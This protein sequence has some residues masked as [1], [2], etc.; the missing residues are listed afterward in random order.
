MQAILVVVVSA[1]LSLILP[2]LSYLSGAAVALVTLRVGKQ[3]GLLLVLWA[4]LVVAVAGLLLFNNPM[5]ALAFAFALW[6]P[7][8][9]MAASLRRTARPARSIVL[10]AV[11]GLM[12]VVAFH[13]S[14]VDTTQWWF[15]LLRDAL[16]AT[17]DQL[18]EAERAQMLLNLEGIA[19]LMTGVSGAALSA[20]LI[21]SLV[22]GRWWQA[23]LYNPGGF[24]DE[25]RRISLGRG[26]A[27]AALL[28]AV[29]ALLLPSQTLL[30]D[31]MMVA[32]V[33]LALQGLAV[34]HALVKLRGA[35]GAWLVAL[36]VLAFIA[37]GH[38]ALLLA[39]IGTVDNWLDFRRSFGSKGGAGED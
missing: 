1:L 22:L 23:V 2:P 39:L 31:L 14:V 24:G 34:V 28:L 11:Y 33:P 4:V 18:A 30:R 36:Y 9:A 16:S 12:A 26:V 13:L 8:W 27:L 29:A 19:G 35:A 5:A 6:L 21:G 37:T 15:G 32:L 20:S 17:L 38:M 10:A 7:V 3:Q 25:F